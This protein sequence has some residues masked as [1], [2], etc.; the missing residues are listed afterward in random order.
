MNPSTNNDVSI[1]TQPN[2]CLRDGRFVFLKNSYLIRVLM[3]SVV[4]IYLET[5]F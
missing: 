1:S 2:E 5:S 4:G 3:Y